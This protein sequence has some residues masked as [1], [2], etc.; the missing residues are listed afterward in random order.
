M[1]ADS[2][3]RASSG[4]EAR[5]GIT[6]CWSSEVIAKTAAIVSS[7]I[8][9]RGPGCGERVKK[10]SRPATRAYRSSSTIVLDVRER[11]AALRRPLPGGQRRV[12]DEAVDQV[13][14]GAVRP[15]VQQRGAEVAGE[16]RGHLQHVLGPAL[17]GLPLVGAHHAGHGHGDRLGGRG[18]HIGAEPGAQSQGNTHARLQRRGRPPV[19]P[20]V[21]GLTPGS[22]RSGTG[23]LGACPR[24]TPSGWPRSG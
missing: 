6:N 20:V 7:V 5:C 1:V 13:V 22:G 8:R 15:R 2:S 12:V 3:S 11:R 9:Q 16:P 21:S 18:R 24:E 14:L 4:H 17:E 19:I 10:L 23:T